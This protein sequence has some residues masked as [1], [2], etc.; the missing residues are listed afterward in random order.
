M[1]KCIKN[2]LSSVFILLF[3]LS[4]AWAEQSWQVLEGN[5][6]KSE[7]DTR[8]YQAITLANEMHVLLVHDEKAPKSLI[9]V[10][11]PIGS[12]DDPDSQ[13][14]LAHYLEHMVFMGSKNYPQP[15][16][17]SEFLSKNSG[18]YNASTAPNQTSFYLEVDNGEFT[19]ALDLLSDA[20]AEP[21]LN[22]VYADKERNA[23]NAEL[24]MA[25]SRDGIRLA[26]VN[27]ETVNPKHPAAKFFGGNLE[28][29][30]DK[31][32]SKLQD[33]LLK[34]YH[35]YY[36]S[37]I[38][39]AV[40]YSNRPL[41]ELAKLASDSFGRISNHKVTVPEIKQPLLTEKEQGIIIHYVPVQPLKVLR[42]NFNV[43]NNS[44]EFRSKADTY[45]AYMIGNRSKNTLADWLLK[46]GLAD[47]IESNVSPNELRN[48]GTFSIDISLTDKGL[49]Q[50]E[51]II[52]AVFA[53]LRLIKKQGIKAE[54]FTEMADIL[55]LD[56]QYQS[57]TRDMGYVSSLA[58]TLLAVP[59]QY[60]L[61]ADYLADNYQ[62]ELIQ[63]RL[64]ELTPDVARIW[65]ISPNEPHDKTA[66]FVDALYQVEKIP[67]AQINQW[68]TGENA[69]ALSL[70]EMN[71]YIPNDFSLIDNKDA[72]KK[73]QLLVENPSI[74]VL[75]MPSTYFADEPKADITL[76][77]RTPFANESAR[78]QVLFTLNEYLASLALA[79]L[80]YQAALGGI[81]FTV[82]GSNGAAFSAEGFT[83][84]LPELLKK[85]LIEYRDF[86]PTQLQLEQAKINYIDQLDGAEKVRSFKLAMQPI[87]ALSNVPYTER[88]VRRQL[89]KDITLDEVNNYRKQLLVTSK[90]EMLVVGNLTPE[91]IKA[92]ADDVVT[93]M[94]PQGK[95]W[96]HGQDVIIDKTIRA[97]FEAKASSTDGALVATYIPMGY[98]RIASVAR[99]RLL[100]QILHSWFF[101]QLRTEE[102]LG[103]ALFVSSI[104]VGH[105]AGLSFIL[106][107]SD[108]SPDYL[109][110][111]YQVFF[112]QT[113]K[114]LASLSDVEFKQ[115]KQAVLNELLQ[116]PQTLSEEASRFV[117]DFGRT[118]YQFD[119][120]DK[121]IEEITNLQLSDIVNFFQ[122][123]VVEQQGLSV[124]SQV[125]GNDDNADK[126]IYATLP[127]DWTT[128]DNASSLQQQ[129][130]HKV[131]Q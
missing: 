30:R 109:Y 119:S 112:E 43:K 97:N 6:N 11:L 127:A 49:Q 20:L 52:N 27:N 88:S 41:N 79:Q 4:A 94:S 68:K 114:R 29:L 129:F 85:L 19:G 42:I 56:F 125:I 71:P 34:F 131:R 99:S 95:V 53:Y 81:N 113:A 33:E 107:S 50:R 104:S 108:K 123:A 16:G 90:P 103:Y 89:V 18:S 106:Q 44:N 120:R 17:L 128:F 32:D 38:M 101:T 92:L 64:N 2:I 61:N 87:N 46:Q 126:S 47:D 96:W 25:R 13:Q 93:I 12:L 77:F 7:K 73:P 28:T 82:S 80:N 21:L 110:Q 65:Y 116:K 14:G 3:C 37:N 91:R 118:N 60:V 111:R 66:Y 86:V 98:D 130:T 51:D 83:Q 76:A 39:V 54:Y 124:L 55:K 26:Q 15:D 75:Y 31:P 35:N 5:I 105:Q 74:R 9:G 117:G 121:L 22:P 69:P 59:Y 102:Q 10:A 24:T 70:P 78:N 115:Y 100:E 67:Q 36:S 62:P 72:A 48:S 23:V 57:I 40:L 84:H 45:L 58:S 122:Q 8:Q 63:Q 1:Y